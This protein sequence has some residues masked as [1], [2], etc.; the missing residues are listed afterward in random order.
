MLN[1]ISQTE[2]ITFD[3]GHSLDLFPHCSFSPE[4]LHPLRWSEDQRSTSQ[5]NIRSVLAI[6]RLR[7]GSP[8]K[9]REGNAAALFIK[10]PERR[11]TPRLLRLE[12]GDIWW[13]GKK[14]GE[15]PV[16]LPGE[17][18]VENQVDAEAAILIEL[19]RQGIRAEI[20]QGIL[21]YPTGHK[22]LLTKGIPSGYGLSRDGDRSALRKIRDLEQ[23]KGWKSVDFFHTANHIIDPH[24]DLH[25][26]DVNRW[27]VPS[28]TDVVHT[29]LRDLILKQ[30]Q[31]QNASTRLSSAA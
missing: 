10:S 12:K 31:S 21:E 9:D 16:T 30:L 14:S 8:L 25:V 6:D 28:I 2:Q 27:K 1:S 13:G 29:T 26:I 11:F 4:D 20:P 23:D 19:L 18:A 22:W 24:G 15:K 7:D 17:D 5:G 3:S